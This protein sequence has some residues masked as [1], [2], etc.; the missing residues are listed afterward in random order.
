MKV[1]KEGVVHLQNA[2]GVL[3][4]FQVASQPEAV[5]RDAEIMAV[6]QSVGLTPPVEFVHKKQFTESL[7]FTRKSLLQN[8]RI[9][10]D[11]PP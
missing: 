8:P 2:G 9:S 5:F 7:H 3:R 6:S 4:S 11:P 10:F 1:E